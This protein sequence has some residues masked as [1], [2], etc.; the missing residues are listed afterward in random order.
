[1][2]KPNDGKFVSTRSRV[3]KLGIKQGATVCL[4]NLDDTELNYELAERGATIVP[5]RSVKSAAA[6]FL[7]VASLKDLAKLEALRAKVAD[8]AAVWVIRGKGKNAVVSDSASRG[9]GLAAGFVDVKV[10][11]F[12]ATRSAEKYVIPLASRGRRQTKKRN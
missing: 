12:G 8:D 11:S 9:A 3:D 4:I 1:M 2:A 10:V 7:G 5:Y 6:V